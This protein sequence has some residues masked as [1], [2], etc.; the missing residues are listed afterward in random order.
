MPTNFD[1]PASLYGSTDHFDVYYDP[2]LTI[3]GQTVARGIV[4]TCERDLVMLLRFF[5]SFMH[6][7]RL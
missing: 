6:L 7:A 4:E 1:H 2:I 5:P 3:Y